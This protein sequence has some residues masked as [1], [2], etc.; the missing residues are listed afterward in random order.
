MTQQKSTAEAR[1]RYMKLFIPAMIGYL[2][3]VVGMELIENVIGNPHP[4]FFILSLV[5]AV[6]VFFWMWAH[7][8]YVRECDELHRRIQIE[9]MIYGLMITMA[10]V[11]IWG[12][13][14]FYT[15]VPAIPIFYAMPGF[16]LGYG[17]ASFFVGRKYGV[18]CL[19]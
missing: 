18:K 12:F 17:L 9:A 14:E 8:R 11:T 6:S 13:W 5:P 4:A 10:G 19:P 3:S 15:N 2:L 16:Y 7:A 1:S